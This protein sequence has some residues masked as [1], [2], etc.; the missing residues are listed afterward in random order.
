MKCLHCGGKMR[1]GTA[2]FHVDRR[3]YHLT[4]DAVPAWICS[5]C[6]EAFFEGAEVEAIQKVL[7]TVDKQAEKLIVA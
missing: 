3:G 7:R 2:P 1:R 6:G 4:W 5:Q